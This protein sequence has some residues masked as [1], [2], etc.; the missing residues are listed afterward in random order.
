LEE[1][2]AAAKDP[3]LS[4]GEK[5]YLASLCSQEM[6][7][8]QQCGQCLSQCPEKLPIP[9]LMRAYM[10]AYGYKNA[11]LSK[12]TLLE[13]NLAQQMCTGCDKCTVKCVSGFKVSEKIAAITPVMQVSDVFL[14]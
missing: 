9:D 4:S 11:S 12:E 14:T 1:C 3:A 7:Y 10:Y 5:E 2:L 8:C 6:L 13:L